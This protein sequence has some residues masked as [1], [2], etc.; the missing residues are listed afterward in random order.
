MI[1]SRSNIT[2]YTHE[3]H[4]PTARRG[5]LIASAIYVV[6]MVLV[7]WLT[8]CNTSPD[9][10]EELLQGSILIA[11]GEDS[12]EGA[13]EVAEQEVEPV[14][15][16]PPTPEPEPVVEEIATDDSSEVE[17]PTP[18]ADQPEE[19]VTPVREVNKR[20]LFPG[21]TPKAD[22]S[23]GADKEKSSVAGSSQGSPNTTE[24]ILGSGLSGDFNLAGRTLM[25]S[26]PVPQY[27]EQA[28]GRVVM[29]ITVDESGRVTSAS[30]QATS[31]TTNNSKL[32]EAAREAALKAQ[33]ST[34]ESF[35]QSGTITY[36][37]KLN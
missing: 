12:S 18:E 20:A 36:I 25:G 14:V 33:F 4:D 2:N 27:N 21:T 32:I 3:S 9:I 28:E 5:G 31:S 15:E 29:N 24:A 26:L 22:D 17:V 13:G 16:S 37:F 19:V 35:V 1:N 34:S 8:Q 11:F 10:E 7:M 30:L 23:Q 6:A